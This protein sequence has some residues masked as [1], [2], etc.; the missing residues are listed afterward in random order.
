MIRAIRNIA[1]VTV[2]IWIALLPCEAQKS[3]KGFDDILEDIQP[4]VR[5]KPGII[6]LESEERIRSNLQEFNHQAEDRR[7]SFAKS[8][9]PGILKETNLIISLDKDRSR[10]VTCGGSVMY[11]E[12]TLSDLKELKSLLLNA[13]KT[14]Y[15]K[16]KAPAI[17][18]EAK[19][20]DAYTAIEAMLSKDSVWVF[21][22]S[23]AGASE[24]CG[25]ILRGQSAGDIIRLT[26]PVQGKACEKLAIA[27]QSWDESSGVTFKLIESGAVVFEFKQPPGRYSNHLKELKEIFNSANFQK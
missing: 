17:Q 19:D 5:S 14:D 26:K 23:V 7:R 1:L 24:N 3:S 11:E 25:L 12:V 22:R 27:I 4:Y 20:R 2:S 10:Q 16:I 15:Y 8:Y 6:I 21:R 13:K 9:V 18:F